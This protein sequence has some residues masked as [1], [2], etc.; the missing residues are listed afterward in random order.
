MAIIQTVGIGVAPND[1]TGDPLRTAFTKINSNFAAL[2][3]EVE[4]SAPTDIE[5]SQLA[6]MPGKT[7]KGRGHDDVAGEPRDLTESELRDLIGYFSETQRGIVR[8][9]GTPASGRVLADSNTWVNLGDPTTAPFTWQVEFQKGV[10]VPNGT[11]SGTLSMA[12]HS[13][14]VFSTTGN[15][16]VPN[17]A[18]F[19]VTLKIGGAHTIGAGGATTAFAS[20]DVVS[21]IVWAVG[22][23][24]AH[25]QVAADVITLPTS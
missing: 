11:V 17:E 25:K 8:E 6:E 24:T 21:V 16:T 20:G 22:T 13:G 10:K 2:N 1:G 7:V 12:E 5:N 9:I 4:S 15:V 18:G 19:T 14:G 23:V 3:A